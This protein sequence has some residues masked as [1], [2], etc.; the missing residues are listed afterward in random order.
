MLGNLRDYKSIFHA[1]ASDAM[2]Y[3]RQHAFSTDKIPPLC[4]DCSWRN[5]DSNKRNRQLGAFVGAQIDC[6]A[7]SPA[8]A[9]APAP[10]AKAACG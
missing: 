7:P 1:Y 8:V 10:V 9:D 3:W 2:L 5:S 4:Q 6:F